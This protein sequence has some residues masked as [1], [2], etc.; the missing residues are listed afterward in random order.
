MRV[1]LFSTHRSQETDLVKMWTLEGI[2]VQGVF[3][4]YSPQRPPVIGVTDPESIPGRE[5]NPVVVDN[6]EWSTIVERD[7]DLRT[8]AEDFKGFDWYV[9]MEVPERARRVIHYAKMGLNVC[10]QCFGQETDD[11]DST[12][13]P[14]LK[15]YPRTHLV[16]YSEQVVNRYLKLGVSA[17]Q[18]HLIRFGFYPEDY[19][20]AGGWVG[21]LLCCMTAHNSI[22]LRG[23]GCSWAQYR[24][25]SAGL[26]FLLVGK[27]TDKAGGIGEQSYDSL[28]L[29]Y[30][31]ALCYLSMGTKPAPYTMA[32]I[33]A[34]MSGCPIMFYDNE[35][36]IRNEEWVTSL[37]VSSDVQDL[38]NFAAM[39]FDE[40]LKGDGSD[41]DPVLLLSK[42]SKSVAMEYFN[43][44]KQSKKWLQFFQKGMEPLP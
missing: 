23:E 5:K 13:V 3:D 8:T 40:S 43:A 31:R 42:K 34:M 6:E 37:F 41:N 32:P 17:R 39:I 11:E 14:A 18:V 25:I 35:C 26:P 7:R 4:C 12:L 36:G 10:V 20:P 22:N 2:E 21:D 24:A 29:L 38:R 1:W 33:E 9:M 28:K 19:R 15:E 30:S 27:D 44:H 16:C